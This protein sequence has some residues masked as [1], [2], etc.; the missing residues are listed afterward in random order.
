MESQN[1]RQNFQRKCQFQILSGESQIRWCSD[2]L[3][4]VFSV[5]TYSTPACTIHRSTASVGWRLENS[6]MF[7][8]SLSLDC[9]H[10]RTS[11]KEVRV[12]TINIKHAR[13]LARKAWNWLTAARSNSFVSNMIVLLLLLMSSFNSDNETSVSFGLAPFRHLIVNS[14]WE[15]L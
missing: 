8:S 2:A 6:C 5:Y 4:T 1:F 7:I 11:N 3:P 10:I 14:W 13:E 15:S 9:T 12:Q